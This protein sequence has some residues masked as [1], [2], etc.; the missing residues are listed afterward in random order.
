MSPEIFF[1]DFERTENSDYLHGVFGRCLVIATRFDSM[2]IRLSKAIKL[3]EEV[4]LCIIE[5][6]LVKLDTENEINAIRSDEDFDL[7][8]KQ[9]TSRYLSLDKSIQNLGLPEQ[10][11]TKLHEARKSRN[12]IAHSLTRDLDGCIDTKIDNNILIKKVEKLIGNIIEGD[13]IISTITSIFNGE[14]ILN[15]KI[16]SQYK[17]KIIDWVITP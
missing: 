9:I 7:L 3:K 16:L 10:L 12:E 8:I 17:E 14:P 11:S 5:K 15:S 1:D 13:I 2:C 4:K 6:Y